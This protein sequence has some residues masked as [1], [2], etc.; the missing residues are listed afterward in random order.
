VKVKGEKNKHNLRGKNVKSGK[1]KRRSMA[2][3]LKK[4]EIM[5]VELKDKIKRSKENRQY[6][7]SY[8]SR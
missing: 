6:K 1:Q 7:K 2:R 3:R 4:E 8:C 5:E